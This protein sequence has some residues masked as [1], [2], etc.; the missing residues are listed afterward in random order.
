MEIKINGTPKEIADLALELQNRLML[1]PECDSH[2]FAKQVMKGVRLVEAQS[3]KSEEVD[4][5]AAQK[6]ITEA[7]KKIYDEKFLIDRIKGILLEHEN[8]FKESFCDLLK[9]HD[10]SIPKNR[11]FF[12]KHSAETIINAVSKSIIR[13]IW[14]I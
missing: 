14:K 4:F 2:E 6:R 7:A 10:F 5:A 11:D 3:Q 1:N 9:E 13:E 12:Y 8:F